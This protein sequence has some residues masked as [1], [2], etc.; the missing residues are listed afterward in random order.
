MKHGLWTSNLRQGVLY[1]WPSEPCAVKEVDSLVPTNAMGVQR[2]RKV[3]VLQPQWCGPRVTKRQFGEDLHQIWWFCWQLVRIA[4]SDAI[5]LD[6]WSNQ[7]VYSIYI[8]PI[9]FDLW[10]IVRGCLP[11]WMTNQEVFPHQANRSMRRWWTTRRPSCGAA[12]WEVRRRDLSMLLGSQVFE[13]KKV[14][15]RSTKK[16]SWEE[17]EKW[18]K[19][20]LKEW[21]SKLMASIGDNV[22]V[23]PG[24][25]DDF[26]LDIGSS[27]PHNM[28][29]Q[30]SR[31]SSRSCKSPPFARPAPN[32]SNRKPGV[33]GSM[34]R[35]FTNN[36]E[37]RAKNKKNKYKN[38]KQRIM[39]LIHWS[40]L[41]PGTSKRSLVEQ[42][43][44]ALPGGKQL[45]QIFRSRKVA[46]F[47]QKHYFWR[48]KNGEL[49]L[50]GT[51]FF[52]VE[53]SWKLTNWKEELLVSKQFIVRYG[54]WSKT[55][56]PLTV[57][58]GKRWKR[59]TCKRCIM[60]PNV[61]ARAT[62]KRPVFQHP[63]KHVIK[64]VRSCCLFVILFV[65]CLCCWLLVGCLLRT[66]FSFRNAGLLL[67]DS[68]TVHQGW[69]GGPRLAMPICWE[70]RHRRS[71][72]ISSETENWRFVHLRFEMV[73]DVILFDCKIVSLDAYWTF[74]ARGGTHHSQL[75]RSVAS[76]YTPCF[77]IHKMESCSIES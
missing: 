13:Q 31:W 65:V 28:G 55:M 34:V 25:N 39:S 41:S 71:E 47:G 63:K 50:H 7:V 53:E 59:H 38:K 2:P 44:R 1:I 64:I 69:R 45:G 61:V 35:S 57:H 18:R 46:A 14:A 37:P 58:P 15:T 52:W 22:I 66:P 36:Q 43:P 21:T 77:S 51:G 60:Y 6:A 33:S 32:C 20:D 8:L 9:L 23:I 54:F 12:P 29:H 30:A 72:E 5:K 42:S 70:P 11:N 10:W 76:S 26:H 68:R 73:H 67:W 48:T 3:P 75:Q 27:S 24:L 56:V 4:T 74:W 49:N 17:K 16:R 19:H 40:F 62:S